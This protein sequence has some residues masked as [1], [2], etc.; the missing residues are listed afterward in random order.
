MLED[1]LFMMG[2]GWLFKGLFKNI[3]PNTGHEN[4]LKAICILVI[5]LTVIGG[6]FMVLL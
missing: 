5:M 6:L 2:V 4:W 1:I 3:E